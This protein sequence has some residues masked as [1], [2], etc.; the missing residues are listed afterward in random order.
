MIMRPKVYNIRIFATLFTLT[1][2]R[3]ARL[4]QYRAE[5]P[6]AISALPAA[7][8]V[9]PRNLTQVASIR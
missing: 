2:A 8:F 7:V 5:T 9:G 3:L 6:L 1:S 4:I